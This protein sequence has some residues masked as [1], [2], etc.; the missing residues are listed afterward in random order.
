MITMLPHHL[1]DLPSVRRQHLLIEF[2]GLRTTCP[3]G[4]YMS[5][6]PGDPTLWFGV[7][8][9]RK[10]PY[11]SAILRF[12]ISF[13]QPFPWFPPVV[14]FSTDMFHPL[15]TP[16]TTYMYT[17][18]SQ[19]FGTVSTSDD[20]R[21]PPGGFSLRHGFPGW[22]RKDSRRAEK[23]HKAILLDHDGEIHTSRATC[24]EGPNTSAS[25]A[26]DI[27]VG[28]KSEQEMG[29]YELLR[30]IRS[31]FDNEDVLDQ[32][33]LDIAGNP[34]A[35]HAWRTHR[36][37]KDKKKMAAD[38]TRSV[39]EPQ[40][41][42]TE[43]EVSIP[44][45]KSPT[46][47]S[48]QSIQGLDGAGILYTKTKKPGE[49]NWDGVWEVRVKKCIEASVSESVLFGKDAAD[50]LIRFLHLDSTKI[51]EL[52]ENIKRS[53]ENLELSRRGISDFTMVS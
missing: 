41:L 3:H 32:V 48:Q 15:I 18:D 4:I 53:L 9:I 43:G 11:A 44:L 45:N 7:M 16:L 37:N 38:N 36:T 47:T 19:M 30:Y 24:K 31:T 28:K 21:L 29:I 33:A 50:D 27:P 23:E 2:S 34:G 10:G 46:L 22:F 49:W 35:W 5:I 1:S 14:T 8:F 12:Q 51:D 52:K 13:I 20:E 17:T 6:A 25:E 40:K 26:N 42:T 39:V